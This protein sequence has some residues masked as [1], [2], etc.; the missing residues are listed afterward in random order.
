MT[1]AKSKSVMTVAADFSWPP[2]TETSFWCRG[3]M[4][5]L[6]ILLG[7]IGGMLLSGL[8]GLFVGAVVLALGYKIFQA[9]LEPEALSDQ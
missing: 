7:V 5:T 1:R 3:K 8:I 6:V 9:L 2:K 4:P